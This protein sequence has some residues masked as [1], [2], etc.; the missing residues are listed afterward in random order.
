MLDQARLDHVV[1]LTA[2]IHAAAVAE[3]RLDFDDPTTPVVGT[4]LV[5]APIS[6][7]W[8]SDDSYAV[9]QA[10][11]PLNPHI[12]SIDRFHGYLRCTIE[13]DELRA[14]YRMVD[15][16]RTPGSPVHTHSSWTIQHD[17]GRVRRR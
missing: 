8:M 15:S 1:V 3:L 13:R 5:T 4:E 14:D 10:S 12:L 7:V 2:D 6:S 9:L 16:V 17:E 11:A